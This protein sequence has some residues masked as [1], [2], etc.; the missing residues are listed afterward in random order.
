MH[1]DG[2]LCWFVEAC[3]YKQQMV[4]ALTLSRQSTQL[5]C[6]LICDSVICKPPSSHGILMLDANYM[7]NVEG[8]CNGT[9]LER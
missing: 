4:T 6:F 8:V 1:V 7:L 3:M 2:G 5:Y 9:V